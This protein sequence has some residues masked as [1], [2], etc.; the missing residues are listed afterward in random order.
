MPLNV[1]LSQL[2]GG[3]A[4]SGTVYLDD[5]GIA[6]GPNDVVLKDGG[7]HHVVATY[8]STTGEKA[9][10]VD[11]MKRW[12]YSLGAGAL[13]TSGGGANAFIG[14]SAGGENFDGVIDE[15]A[16]WNRGLTASE[17]AAHYANILG[18]KNYF[19]QSGVGLTGDTDGD[20]DVDLTDLNNVRNNFGGAGLG[21]TDSDGD[22]DL[23]DLNNVRNNF[24]AVGAN[25]VPEPASW[26]ML[27][28]ASAAMFARRNA[29]KRGR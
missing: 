6:L 21:D 24:G 2:P 27:A 14:S 13:I 16:F 20:G 10:Y 17:I 15:V 3:S 26:T 4:A 5:P 11:G 29:W 1:D 23:S 8:D 28:I 19:G 7:V 22:V 25:A 18:D 9:I 12:A